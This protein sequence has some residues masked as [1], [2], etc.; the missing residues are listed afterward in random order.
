MPRL[1][2]NFLLS[3]RDVGAEHYTVKEI[4]DMMKPIDKVDDS[5]LYE[6]ASTVS[7]YLET[8]TVATDEN[9]SLT[10]SSS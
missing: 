9:T 5:S 4:A 1:F 8:D 3:A 2:S 10:K 6:F 7:F